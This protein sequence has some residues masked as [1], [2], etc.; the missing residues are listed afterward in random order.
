MIMSIA[1]IGFTW[2]KFST[3]SEI[4]MLSFKITYHRTG[5]GSPVIF[6]NQE[7][8]TYGK[9]IAELGFYWQEKYRIQDL[10]YYSCY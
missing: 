2:S 3:A 5:F 7:L 4:A 10:D 9:L 6:G 1:E 8:I